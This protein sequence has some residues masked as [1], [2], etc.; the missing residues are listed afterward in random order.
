MRVVRLTRGMVTDAQRIVPSLDVGVFIS[1]TAP[2]TNSNGDSFDGST[3]D[4]TISEYRVYYDMI[5]PP[6]TYVAET[7]NLYI[8]LVG[9]SAGTWYIGVAAVDGDG[10]EGTMSDVFT[11]V[12][13]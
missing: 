11:K 7:T 5:S 13:T 2:A 4:R 8:T 12:V 10:D 6:S 1:W 3:P 9:L